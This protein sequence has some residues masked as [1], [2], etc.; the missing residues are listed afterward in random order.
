MLLAG[1]AG[2]DGGDHARATR[3]CGTMEL[4]GHELALH[5]VGKRIQCS[6]VRAIVRR[7]CHRRD[8]KVW[9]CHSFQPPDPVVVWF[10]ARERF[11][12]DYS[13]AIEA[14]RYPCKDAHV[15]PRAWAAASHQRGD[16]FPSRLKVLADDIV[17]CKLL[18]GKTYHQVQAL[19]GRGNAHREHHRHYI[20]I[21]VGERRD[22]FISIDPEYFTLR[23]DRDD[24]FRSASF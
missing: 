3:D 19:V 7:G 13:T 23:F 15:T 21:A 5:V 6:Q 11:T 17:R 16:A 12:Y 8:G 4:Y 20:E 14:R 22:S 24:V 10:P 2:C 18:A 1:V 9:A